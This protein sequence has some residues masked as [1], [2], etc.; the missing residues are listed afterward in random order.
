MMKTF[1]E[2]ISEGIDTFDLVKW[3]RA[4][5]KGTIDRKHKLKMFASDKPFNVV[6]D[7]GIVKVKPFSK[8]FMD[9]GK[10]SNEINFMIG[11]KPFA[12]LQGVASFLGVKI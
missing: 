6:T 7:K 9:K 5:K 1:K 8:T 11:N 4:E 3:A 12:T 10:F 2:Y